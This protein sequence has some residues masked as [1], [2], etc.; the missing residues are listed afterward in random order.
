MSIYCSIFEIGWAHKRGCP[1][2]FAGTAPCTCR[3]SPLIYQGSHVL[4]S[5]RDKR[6]GEVGFSAIRGHVT[7]RGRKKLKSE[8]SWH[9]WIR[10]HLD[11]KE[12]RGSV[13]L[14]KK[15]VEK[16]RDALTKY[17]DNTEA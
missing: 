8:D 6:A 4:P 13:V 12:V 16:L 1:G 10:F 17:L 15:Q 2:Y 3:S 7:K 5:D 14:T 9:P 11:T